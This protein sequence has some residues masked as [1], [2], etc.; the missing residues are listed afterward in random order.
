MHQWWLGYPLLNSIKV[1]CSDYFF[2]EVVELI[3]LGG[4]FHF[5]NFLLLVDYEFV[6]IQRETLIQ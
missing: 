2:N 5:L 4:L 6:G 3:Y 1:F